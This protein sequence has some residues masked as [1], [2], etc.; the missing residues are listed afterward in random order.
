MH[1]GERR[2]HGGEGKAVIPILSDGERAQVRRYK[3][4]SWET[5]RDPEPN[6]GMFLALGTG[7][8]PAHS[9]PFL[10]DTWLPGQIP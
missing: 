3:Q 8:P 9:L 10:L 1:Q 2:Q 5:V 7:H 6:C 4:S